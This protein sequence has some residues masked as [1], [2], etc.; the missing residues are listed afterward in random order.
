MTYMD[1]LTEMRACRDALDWLLAGGY[2]T[3]QAA[4]DACQRSDWMIWLLYHAHADPVRLRML[5]CDCAER[6]LTRD[7]ALSAL[8]PSARTAGARTAATG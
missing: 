3:L 4:W 1:R 7:S 2:P 6:A 5:A 8:S